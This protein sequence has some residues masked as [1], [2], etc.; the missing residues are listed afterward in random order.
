MTPKEPR[1]ASS[2][3]L[4]LSIALSDSVWTRPLIDGRI[5]PDGLRLVP[6]VLHGSEMFWRQLRFGDFAASEMSL[7]SLF[8]ACARGDTRWAA[9][10]VFTMRRFFHTGIL[11]RAAAGIDKPADLAGKRVG[12]PEYQQTSAVWSRGILQE[13][14][15]VAPADIEWYMERGADRSHGSATG[16]TPPRGIRLHQIA[17][18]SDIGK[19][20]LAGEL[21]ASLLYLTDR[22]L[23]DRSR[24]DV[25]STDA[26]RRLFPEPR[27]EGQRYYRAT[28][29][30]PINHTVVVKR[31]LLERH[32]WIALNLYS[33]FVAAKETARACMDTVLTSY[34]DTGLLAPECRVALAGDP[35]PYGMKGARNELQTVARYLHE[36]GLTEREVALEEVFAPSTLDL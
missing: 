26:V 28:G 5:A 13:H 21:D 23:V 29:L 3:T 17:P 14:F 24:I 33:S 15:G 11:V 1:R 12:V 31:A 4:T 7:A 2:R 36:Q 6:S 25:E 8:I 20:L 18:G 27:A 22:N 32:P 30:F 35:M 34:F 19:M 10:P 16:F 9:V